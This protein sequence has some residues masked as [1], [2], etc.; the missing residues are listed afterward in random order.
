LL[1]KLR[2]ANGEVCGLCHS[3]TRFASTQHHHHKEGGE[4]SSCP[5]CHMAV[6]TYMVIH[7]RHDHSFR[8]P[9]PD[10][11]VSYGT[12]NA[13]NDCHRNKTAAWAAQAVD[14]WYGG[15]HRGY[16]QFAGQLTAARRQEPSAAAGLL[17]LLSGDTTPAIVR[18]TALS[19]LRSY[20]D[21]E[22]VAAARK[23]LQ[24]GDGLVRL[25]AVELLAETDGATRWQALSGALTDP[26]L[27]VRAAAADAVADAVPGD[28]APDA[29]GA[30]EHALAEYIDTQKLNADRPE[31]RVSLGD[32][33][34]R[35]GKVQDAE[36]E[37]RGAIMLWPFFLPAYL[38]LADLSRASG[39]D[40]QTER[41]LTAAAKVAPRSSALVYA[42][43][44]LR[45]R[46]HRIAESLPLLKRAAE[47]S[48]EEPRYAYAYGV[49]L[50]SAGR[51]S[52]GLSI[53]RSAHDRFPGNR[54][55]LLGLASLS[56]DS[57]DIA[58]ARRYAESFALMAPSDPRG[59]QML[60][61]LAPAPP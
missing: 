58:A 56:A 35:V 49:G 4:G 40:D 13:C 8:I 29:A 48:P 57:G 6:R 18:A 45:V 14:R 26:N 43:G 41:W 37:Y 42:L 16:Q 54:E 34:A 1:Q 36:T 12:P 28:I 39:R 61:Q 47:L 46:Q 3:L 20:L 50:Y 2:T 7:Q 19:E 11:S 52:Q 53:L 27:A 55:L 32:L 22:S 15:V 38:N 51:R 5:A 10:D 9:R 31:A 30:F 60:A 44:L 59:R 25:A 23:G 33:Y 21:P 24:S 17:G